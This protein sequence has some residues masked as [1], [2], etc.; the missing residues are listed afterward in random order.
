MFAGHFN[1]V[2]PIVAGCSWLGGCALSCLVLGLLLPTSE[3]YIG[4]RRI[5]AES[6]GQTA[7]LR[8]F[9]LRCCVAM[10][11]RTRTTRTQLD[12]CSGRADSFCLSWATL[13]VALH[14]QTGQSATTTPLPCSG[15]VNRQGRP[16]DAPQ[17]VIVGRLPVADVESRAKGLCRQVSR[18]V[19]RGVYRQPR[20]VQRE[21]QAQ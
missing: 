21:G 18:C 7:G 1:S 19:R 11:P 14:L 10:R 5:Q 9:H 6:R 4:G 15:C 12:G 3:L 16:L 20:H 8:A 17:E 2:P 13:C